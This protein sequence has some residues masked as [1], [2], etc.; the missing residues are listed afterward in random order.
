MVMACVLD[1]LLPGVFMT[2]HCS[3]LSP[4]FFF[5]SLFFR[6]TLLFSL[7]FAS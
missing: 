7:L 5:V 3:F 2:P 4:L 1:P 6:I